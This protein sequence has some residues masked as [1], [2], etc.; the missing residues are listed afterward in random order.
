MYL[1]KMYVHHTYLGARAPSH[2]FFVPES[3]SGSCA[4]VAG[5]RPVQA[6]RSQP[7][8]PLNNSAMGRIHAL[9]AISR[10]SVLRAGGKE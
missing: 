10:L 6:S 9:Q 8:G 4:R 3:R 2:L 5:M 1:P 7:A